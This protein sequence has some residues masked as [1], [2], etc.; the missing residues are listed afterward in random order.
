MNFHNVIFNVLGEHLKKF[1]MNLM[2]IEYLKAH[3]NMCN[4]FF[5]CLMNFLKAFKKNQ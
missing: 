5:S 3:L 1:L 2:S 4:A